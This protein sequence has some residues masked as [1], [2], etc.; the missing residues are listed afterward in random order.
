MSNREQ[1]NVSGGGKSHLIGPRPQS[2]EQPVA[3][4]IPDCQSEDI[5]N[6]ESDG[7]DLLIQ[8]LIDRLPKPNSPWHLDE[9][10][11]WLRTAISVFDLIYKT[12]DTEH[13]RI[14]VLFTK[15]EPSA[16]PMV[17]PMA[18]EAELSNPLTL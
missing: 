1:W 9:R 4:T 13:L 12:S 5:Q 2:R 7:V 18:P 17:D 6:D 10:A 15:R 16:Q 14:T 11:K 3:S 8:G